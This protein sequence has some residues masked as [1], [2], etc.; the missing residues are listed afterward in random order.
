MNTPADID[1]DANLARRAQAGDL[2][3][4]EALLT[5]YEMRLFAFLRQMTRNGSDAEDIAQTVWVSV[6][7]QLHRY[8]TTRPFSTW[9]FTIAR[10]TAISAWRRMKDATQELQEHDWVDRSHPGTPSFEREEADNLWLWITAHLSAEQRDALWLMY[11]EDMSMR[12]IARTLGCTVI[13][14]KVMLHRARK[15][16]LKAHETAPAP[17]LAAVNIGGST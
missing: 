4:F 6:H 17:S 10:N 13:R 2:S 8:D 14:T 7:R 3:A 15:K 11:R 1:D 12:D 5:R 9:L 16:L